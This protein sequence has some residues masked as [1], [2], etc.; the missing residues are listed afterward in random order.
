MCHLARNG[1]LRLLIVTL[2]SLFLLVC[3]GCTGSSN[4]TDEVLTPEMSWSE[5]ERAA[6]STTI[7]MAMWDGDPLINRYMS[8]DVSRRLL[9]QHQ[10]TLEIIGAQGSEIVNLLKIDREAGRTRGGIDIVWING[11][12]FYQLR[13]LNAL[14]GPFT[15][16][17]PNQHLIDWENPF[18]AKDFQQPIEGYECPWGSVQFTLIY[19]RQRI[20][21][22]PRNREELTQWIKSHPGRFTWDVGFTGMTFLKC[23][24]YDFAG[25]PDSFQGG[26]NPQE[27]QESSRQLWEWVRGIRPTLWRGGQTFPESVTQLHQLFSQGEVDFTMS[28]NDGEVD[29]KVL[30][31]VLPE[32][33]RADVLATGTIRNSHYLG[34][35]WN[36]PHKSA[37][38]VVINELIS[39]EAQWQKATPAVWGDGTVLSEQRLTP[40]WAARFQSLPGRL[41]APP[42]SQIEQQALLE[43]APEVMIQLQQD[44]R[45]EILESSP[46]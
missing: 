31:G 16:R 11:E 35:P 40:E 29:N 23:L 6:H 25:G 43:P 27:Y 17:L 12:N 2:F 20:D 19:D 9:E 42:R 21:Q 44:F 5:I 32:S 36:A 3:H 18:I 46:E 33:A 28:N 14:Y 45:R 4:E 24:L 13:Q 41:R 34:I 8:E 37:A 30:Q 15:S 1:C 39:P 10:I 38:L 26:Y 22:F 7:R